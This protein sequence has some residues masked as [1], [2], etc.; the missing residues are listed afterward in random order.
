[1]VDN[2]ICII[3]SNGQET[4]I[5]GIE[6][7]HIAQNFLNKIVPQRHQSRLFSLSLSK[8]LLVNY[9]DIGNDLEW[10][11]VFRLIYWNLWKQR[12]NLQ[13]WFCYHAHHRLGSTHFLSRSPR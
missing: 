4:V 7:C 6:N 5:L 11:T 8:W 10:I 12:N 3:C 1:M 9:I 2:P 13:C